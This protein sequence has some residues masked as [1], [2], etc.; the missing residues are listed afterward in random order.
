MKEVSRY[1]PLLVALH[2]LLAL[3]VIASMTIGFFL[4]PAMSNS[5]PRKLN[6]LMLHMAGGMLILAL[7]MIRL[8]VRLRT[9]R[10]AELTTGYP[11][12][13]LAWAQISCAG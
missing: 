2:W 3:L 13:D 7:T 4:L 9:R 5:D 8:V 12:L 1:H 10:P 6:I 11:S